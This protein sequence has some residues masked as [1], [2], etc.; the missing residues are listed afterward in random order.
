VLLDYNL[1]GISG[2]GVLEW[3]KTQ[4]SLR[5]VRVVMISSHRDP[6]AINRAYEAGADAFLTK[7]A[8]FGALVELVEGLQDHWGRPRPHE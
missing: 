6:D 2:E 8:G 3:I 4:P 1:P 7:P 5:A